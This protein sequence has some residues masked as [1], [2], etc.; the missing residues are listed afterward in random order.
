M[1]PARQTPED[2]AVDTG[3]AAEAEE[4]VGETTEADENQAEAAGETEDA[5]T[6]GRSMTAKVAIGR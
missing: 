1:N 5:V 3:E 2:V 4:G 6:I